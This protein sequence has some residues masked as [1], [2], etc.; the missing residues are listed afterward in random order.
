MT[1]FP[2]PFTCAHE[3][4]VPGSVDA[5][6]N[7]TA[8]WAAAVEVACV[9]WSPSSAEPSGAPTGGRSLAVDV[10][11]VIDS[12]VDVDHRDRFTIEGR[13]FEVVGVPQDYEH[14]P[15]GIAPGRRVVELVARS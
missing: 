11:L 3:R 5:H 8:A 13:R 15:F 10:V 9:W 2:L 1:V 14:G 12:A 4:Y 6:G 7:T